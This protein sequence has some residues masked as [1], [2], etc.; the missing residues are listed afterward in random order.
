MRQKVACSA[1]PQFG[2]YRPGIIAEF[3]LMLANRPPFGPLSR[4]YIEL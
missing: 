4:R 2:D 1:Y 3:T